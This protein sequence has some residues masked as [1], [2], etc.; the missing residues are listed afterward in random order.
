MSAIHWFEIP[1]SDINRAQTFYKAI[2][3]SDIPL[4]D[5]SAEMGSMLGM[6]PTRGGTGG[7]LVQNAQHGYAPSQQGTMV[8]LVVDGNLDQALERVGQAGGQVML[9]KTPMDENAGGGFIAWIQ[10][11]E[12]NRVGIYSDQ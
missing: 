6:L 4:V 5:M 11:S 8:Y 9:P 2:L 1:V 3:E 7:A 10:D 12:G